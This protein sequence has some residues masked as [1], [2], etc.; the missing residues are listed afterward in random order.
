[1]SNAAAKIKLKINQ[2][3]VCANVEDLYDKSCSHNEN[4]LKTEEKNR[5]ALQEE[6]NENQYLYPI[7]DDPNF[8]IKIAQKKE[9]SDTKYDGTI[10]SVKD[11]ADIISKGE[12]E[13]LPQQAFVRNYRKQITINYVKN[14]SGVEMPNDD[15]GDSA[16]L[17]YFCY[18]KMRE[19]NEE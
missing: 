12:F 15:L 16:G 17:A 19:L 11:Y 3:E 13:L 9:F 10:Y 5:E 2:D 4:M 1:M 14:R 18:D 7:L 6:P 8:N